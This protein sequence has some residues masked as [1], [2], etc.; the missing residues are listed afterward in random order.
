MRSLHC[1]VA[2]LVFVLLAGSGRAQ[3][4]SDDQ[5]ANFTVFRQGV[6]IGAEQVT[7]TRTPQGITIT[8]NERIG[9]PI[10]L[11]ARRAEIRYTADWRPLECLVEGSVRD[12]EVMLHASVAGTTVTTDY[13]QGTKPGHKTDQIAADALL[14]PDIF[15][16][17]YEAL[18]AR[19]TGAKAGDRVNVYIPPTVAATVTVTSVSDDR[20][21][22]QDALVEVRRFALEFGGPDAPA[23]IEL[24]ANPAGRLL[25]FSIPAQ[26]FDIIRSDIASVTSRREPLARPNDERVTIPA[27]GFSLTGTLS[28]PQGGPARGAAFR[29]SCW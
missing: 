6:A 26:G 15:F 18:A 4:V 23:G 8:G 13:L 21:R 16:G 24:W 14:L 1:T 12:E 19:L 7:V 5:P 22:T 20:V 2:L 27:N 10:R 29:R 3:T 11:V 25:R 9:P 28:Q 17:A